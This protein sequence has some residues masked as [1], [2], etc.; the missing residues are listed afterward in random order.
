MS[1]SV[2]EVEGGVCIVELEVEMKV[3]EAKLVI[4]A[5]LNVVMHEMKN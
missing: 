2:A 3:V 5:A 1:L 4:K